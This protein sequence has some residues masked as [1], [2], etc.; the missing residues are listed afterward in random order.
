MGNSLIAVI[1]DDALVRAATTSLL[2]SMGYDC[3][4]FAS[5]D[6]F[7][8]DRDCRYDCVVSDIQMPGM[9]GI[10]LAHVLKSLTPRPPVILITAYPDARAIAAKTSGV[11][12]ALLEK[13]LDGDLFLAAVQSAIKSGSIEG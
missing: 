10:E 9:S 4:D 11:A 3:C 6:A 2:R 5:A 8:S 7:L 13:P 12:S 1:D